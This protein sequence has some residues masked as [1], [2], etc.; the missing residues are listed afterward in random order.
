MEGIQKEANNAK[1]RSNKEGHPKRRRT[2][3]QPTFQGNPGEKRV[4]QPN[5]F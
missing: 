1:K 2:F 3:P 5:N 4:L